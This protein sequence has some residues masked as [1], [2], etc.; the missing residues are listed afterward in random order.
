MVK[1][2]HCPFF[3]LVVMVKN[4]FK[5]ASK[6]FTILLGGRVLRTTLSCTVIRESGV[7]PRCQIKLGE[8][9]CR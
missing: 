3:F 4:N 9:M 2:L 6:I 8:G 1:C 7:F 5:N